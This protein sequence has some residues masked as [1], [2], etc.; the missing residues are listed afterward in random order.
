M[1]TV[2]ECSTF[3]FTCGVGVERKVS[4]L[5]A[6]GWN[7]VLQN[8]TALCG[9]EMERDRHPSYRGGRESGKL[10]GEE[11]KSCSVDGTVGGE[12]LA[13]LLLSG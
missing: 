13:E 5:S 1:K 11:F 3:P 8:V 10:W 6:R 7:A 9:K 4:G 2:V 12:V